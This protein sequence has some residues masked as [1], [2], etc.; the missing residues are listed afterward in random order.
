MT[1]N[2]NVALLGNLI[3]DI[4]SAI[5]VDTKNSDWLD[6]M[7]DESDLSIDDLLNETKN[8]DWDAKL[9]MASDL[10]N[11][12]IEKA[13]EKVNKKERKVLIDSPIN[14]KGDKMKSNKEELCGCGCGK[15]VDKCSCSEKEKAKTTKLN[16]KNAF[17]ADSLKK[18]KTYRLIN[19]NKVAEKILTIIYDEIKANVNSSQI[20]YELCSKAWDKLL[21]NVRPETKI[22][23]RDRVASHL[24]NNGFDVCVGE[25]FEDG[26]LVNLTLDIFW[27]FI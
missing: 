1:K 15:P 17:T 8:V 5:T 20:G 7:I 4:A 16:V 10:M 26:E 3:K 14:V 12:N 24:S 23:V 21:L 19:V 9:K 27:D 22:K 2:M 6:K 18:E 25:Q 13:V 11:K